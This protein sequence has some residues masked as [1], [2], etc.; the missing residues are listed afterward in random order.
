MPSIPINDYLKD[1]QSNHINR[2][3]LLSRR[4]TCPSGNEYFILP[5]LA[6]SS[7]NTSIIFSGNPVGVSQST[8]VNDVG[9]KRSNSVKAELPLQS[10]ELS[11]SD[12]EMYS[13]KN[14]QTRSKSLNEDVKTRSN[15]LNEDHK[16]HNDDNNNNNKNNEDNKNSANKNNSNSGHRN[17]L[18]MWKMAQRQIK[19][20]HAK[21]KMWNNN[22]FRIDNSKELKPLTRRSSSSNTTTGVAEEFVASD[23]ITMNLSVDSSPEFK[24]VLDR[25]D[26]N[27]QIH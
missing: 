5:G 2:P 12:K 1:K 17:A 18:D 19:I 16:C 3:R 22:C 7:D 20:K 6:K 25:F 8:Q 27:V 4:N 15:C 13:N 24:Q 9:A 11:F 26:F 23:A 21:E 10:Q 14:C